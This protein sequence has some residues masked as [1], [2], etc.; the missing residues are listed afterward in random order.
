MQF[1]W[2]A[3]MEFRGAKKRSNIK[4]KLSH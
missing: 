2:D 3:H 4:Q 1:N